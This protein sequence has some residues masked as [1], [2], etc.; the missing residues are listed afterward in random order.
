LVPVRIVHVIASLGVGG[1][2]TL[3]A[4]IVRRQADDGHEVHVVSLLGIQKITMP[5]AVEVH[6]LSAECARPKSLGLVL[7]L[8]RK[9]IVLQGDVV[10]AHMLHSNLLTRLVRPWCRIPMLV[11]TVHS[12]YETSNFLYRM[13]YRYL[14]RV[15]DVTV[16][17]SNEVMGQYV[18]ERLTSSQRSAVVHNGIDTSEFVFDDEARARIREEFGLES[19]AIVIVAIGRLTE[20]KDYPNLLAAFEQLSAACPNTRLLI[21]GDGKLRTLIEQMVKDKGLGPR[22]VFTGIR[23]DMPAIISAGDMLV[24]ASAYEGFGLV[25]AEAMSC[26]VP[27]ATT[28]CGGTAEVIGDCGRL[29]PVRNPEA[30]AA[31]MQ[32]LIQLPSATRK[33]LIAAG[34]E[35]VRNKFSIDATVKSWYGI[36]EGIRS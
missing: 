23:K 22:V 21:V 5:R 11:N 24:L 31:A 36:Y 1:A 17:V 12:I 26:G 6:F 30:L 29:V 4:Q 27:V 32:D 18:K 25:L 19:D 9:L 20:Y 7:A 14:D 33:E 35:R 28:D 2:E 3:L 15:A 8:T 34:R 10:H 13:G 16:F